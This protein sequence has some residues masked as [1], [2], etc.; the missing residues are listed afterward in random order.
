MDS[1]AL[2]QKIHLVF[3]AITCAVAAAGLLN[4]G[5]Y[6]V[7]PRIPPLPGRK[8]P[9]QSSR[10]VLTHDSVSPVEQAMSGPA[11]RT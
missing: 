5:S 1:S 11:A 4:A 10:E 7:Y 9:T 3:Q 8:Q 2:E 6:D